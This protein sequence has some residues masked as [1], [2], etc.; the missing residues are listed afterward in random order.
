MNLRILLVFFVFC[1]STPVLS[2]TNYEACEWYQESKRDDFGDT[3]DFKY[4]FGCYDKFK[5]EYLVVRV[6]KA[7]LGI[8][9]TDTYEAEI[10]KFDEFSRPFTVK[11]KDEYGNI[12]SE[13][14]EMISNKGAIVLD[15]FSQLYTKLTNGKGKVLSVVIYDN[16]GERLNS[17]D[18]SSFK[19]TFK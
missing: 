16:T 8:Y 10:I 7:G 14:T 13:K 6:E 17:F 15:S 11:H 12:Q 18:V 2:Q 5:S 3:E 9:R 19:P 1:V 4:G